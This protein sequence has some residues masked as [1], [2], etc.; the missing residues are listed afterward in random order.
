MVY[1]NLNRDS[2]SGVAF[3]RIPGG[4]SAAPVGKSSSF[5]LPHFLVSWLGEFLVNAEGKEVLDG[6]RRPTPMEVRS[7]LFFLSP[8]TI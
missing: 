2:G 1:G 4:S 8:R 3:S 6:H 5:P 7:S